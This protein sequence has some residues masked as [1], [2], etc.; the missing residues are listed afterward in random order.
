MRDLF[1]VGAGGFGREAVW[2]VERINAASIQPVWRIVG[3]AD[4]D[5]SRASG[6]F[7]GYDLLGSVEQAS[8]DHPGASV[9]IAVGDNAARR[10]IYA[11]LRGHDFP[12]L[13]DP[14]AQVSPTTEFRHGTYVAVGAVVS[15]GTEI[16][17]FVIINARSA[18]GHDSSVGDFSNIAP[19]VSLSG[20]S[21]IGED[22]FMG[23]NSCTA[24]GMKVG[25]GASVACGTPVL[26]DVAPGTVLSPFGTLKRK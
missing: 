11:R 22:V 6:N 1:I 16:G 5:P 3:F 9:F 10:S 2:T 24:P 23:T 17:K 14:A 7:E 4:D 26:A 12:C 18:V 15:V 21:V 19:G 20:H 25:D 13:I 8:K